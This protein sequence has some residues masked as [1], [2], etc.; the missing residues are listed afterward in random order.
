MKN[1]QILKG[2]FYVLLAFLMWGFLAI[3]WKQLK[4]INS[5]ELLANRIIWSFV[6]LYLFL[7]A[8][9]NFSLLSIWRQPKTRYA[10]ITTSILIGINWGLFIYAV[11]AN[12]I[13]QAG[14]GYYITPLVNVFLGIVIL[15]EKLTKT[16]LV[17]LILVS[18]AILYLTISIGQFPYI[19]FI[20]A[21]S[22]GFYGLIKK[23][24]SVN[25]LPSLAFETS[26]LL[27]FALIYQILIWKDGSCSLINNIETHSIL[28]LIGT[29]L[30]TILPLYFFTKGAKQIN[31]TT[32]GFFQYLA[33][34]I[35]LLIG[36]LKYNE[37]FKIKEITAFSI[38]WVA[39]G[40][41]IYSL[42][43]DKS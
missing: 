34:T 27:P 19:S 23:T 13:V 8:T 39:I 35:M 1:K 6:I 3:Y 2:Y 40:I 4:H 41:Y 36:I 7:I 38:I 15:K 21:F 32:V 18:G 17:A 14:L 37:P 16:K 11:N 26:I 25:T 31:L 30:I 28:L 5:W 22:F 9:K 42:I 29:G 10:L 20:L 24:T 12:K 43:K 33:P